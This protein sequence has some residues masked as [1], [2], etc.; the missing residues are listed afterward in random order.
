MIVGDKTVFEDKLK[1]LGIEV[2][3]IDPDGNVIDQE[4]KKPDV[5]EQP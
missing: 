2:R 1:T 4:I 3:E 5:K